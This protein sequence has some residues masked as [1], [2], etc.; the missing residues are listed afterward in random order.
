LFVPV[1]NYVE[2]NYEAVRRMMESPHAILGLSDGG[3]HVGYI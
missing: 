2:S 3:A 1:M